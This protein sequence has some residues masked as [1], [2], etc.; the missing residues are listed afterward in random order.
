MN[1]S[2]SASVYTGTHVCV[3]T[4]KCLYEQHQA[5][6][7]RLQIWPQVSKIADLIA[8]NITWDSFT[9]PF[10]I[11]LQKMAP[12]W[13]GHFKSL[14]NSWVHS[15]KP[16]KEAKARSHDKRPRQED[17][18]RNHSRAEQSR[19]EQS[20]AKQRQ[21]E[22]KARNYDKK[23]RQQ[24]ETRNQAKKSRQAFKNIVVDPRSAA[25]A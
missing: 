25:D 16:T 24:T 19:T 21:Q 4:S 23:P 3:N 9:N 2:A 11:I 10:T 14:R 20:K 22:T 17:T 15:S 1:H 13:V 6:R 18:T 8:S 7:V 12:W 5:S